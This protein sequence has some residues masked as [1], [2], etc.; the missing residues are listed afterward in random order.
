[1][2]LRTAA[3]LLPRLA[4]NVLARRTYHIFHSFDAADLRREIVL[5]QVGEL[6]R[7]SPREFEL[8]ELAAAHQMSETNHSDGKLV[9]RILSDAEA[10]DARSCCSAV[11]EPLQE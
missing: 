10:R 11:E 7:L 8:A 6:V 5:R 3:T 1:V 2:I 9:V 4:G